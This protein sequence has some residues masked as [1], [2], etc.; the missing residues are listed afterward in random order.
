MTDAGDRAQTQHHL[1]IDVQNRDEEDERPE[2]K[3]P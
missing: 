2:E 1:L 3:V